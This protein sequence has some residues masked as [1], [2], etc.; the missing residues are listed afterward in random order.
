LQVLFCFV[1]RAEK[2]A[3]IKPNKHSLAEGQS[4]LYVNKHKVSR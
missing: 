2:A 3:G 1:V 4:V